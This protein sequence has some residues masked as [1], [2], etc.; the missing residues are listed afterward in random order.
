[1]LV[2]FVVWKLVKRTRWVRVNEMDLFTDRYDPGAEGD[3]GDGDYMKKKRMF[4]DTD[5]GWKGKM[6]NAGMWLFF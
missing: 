4:V 5:H 2:M 1:M 3:G 6:K